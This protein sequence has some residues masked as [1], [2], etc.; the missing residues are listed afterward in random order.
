MTKE[1]ADK[2]AKLLIKKGIS[3]FAGPLSVKNALDPDMSDASANKILKAFW[4]RMANSRKYTVLEKMHAE[5]RLRRL[6]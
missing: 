5:E 4:A 1:R 3:G 2:L 6:R